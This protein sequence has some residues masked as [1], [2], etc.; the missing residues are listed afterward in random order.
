MGLNFV[1]EPSLGGSSDTGVD[2]PQFLLLDDR[3]GSPVTD[4]TQNGGSSL[5][6]TPVNQHSVYVQDDFHLGP[7]LVVNLGVRYDVWTGFD[8]DQKITDLIRA[9]KIT[10]V[11][12]V[13]TFGYQ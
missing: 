13:L 4:I 3:I 10:I 12:G 7:R 1:H 11:P 8:L 6:S 2:A 5:F 9:C